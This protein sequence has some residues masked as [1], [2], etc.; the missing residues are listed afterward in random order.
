M[1]TAFNPNDSTDVTLIYED[2]SQL[3][4]TRYFWQRRALKE[5]HSSFFWENGLLRSSETWKCCDKFSCVHLPRIGAQN[6]LS[7]NWWKGIGNRRAEKGQKEGKEASKILP[8]LFCHCDLRSFHVFNQ[9]MIDNGATPKHAPQPIKLGCP[10]S[11]AD[12]GLTK[13]LCFFQSLNI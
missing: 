4:R 13:V 3:R 8:S 2:E 9:L 11:K 1:Q 7:K 12:K 6:M 5:E 10:L